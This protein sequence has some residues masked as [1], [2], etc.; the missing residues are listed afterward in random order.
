MQSGR[1]THYEADLGQENPYNIIFRERLG[2]DSFF[3]DKIFDSKY[4]TW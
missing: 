3:I 2:V 4:L 1:R